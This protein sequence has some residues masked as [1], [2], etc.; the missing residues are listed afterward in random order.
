MPASAGLS[1]IVG[2]SVDWPLAAVISLLALYT[3][4]VSGDSATLTAGAVENAPPEL[5]GATMAL[6]TLIGFA[7]A[8]LGPL[9]VGGLLDI[10]GAETRAGWVIAFAA[11]GIVAGFG[12]W[13]IRRPS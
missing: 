10:F 5:K 6:H 9:A 4:T 3:V 12:P 2:W 13:L 8:S 7:G 1:L 11:M